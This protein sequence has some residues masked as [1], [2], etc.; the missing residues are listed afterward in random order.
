[1]TRRNSSAFVGFVPLQPTSTCSNMFYLISVHQDDNVVF[2][3]DLVL[4]QSF[5]SL[6]ALAPIISLRSTDFARICIIRRQRIYL[7]L[8]SA[9]TNFGMYRLLSQLDA[10]RSAPAKISGQWDSLVWCS[11][12]LCSSVTADHASSRLWKHYTASVVV[13]DL[14]ILLVADVSMKSDVMRTASTRFF[15]LRQLFIRHVVPRLYVSYWWRQSPPVVWTTVTP[16]SSTSPDIMFNDASPWW[17]S[18]S[19]NLLNIKVQPHH[20]THPST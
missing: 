2:L 19:T 4:K 17:T 3:K 13:R 15:E 10:L 12:S 11:E 9:D 20:T 14:G 18:P 1:M 7:E 16:R 5:L 6:V 8:Q